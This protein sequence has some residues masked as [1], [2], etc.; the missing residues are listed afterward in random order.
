MKSKGDFSCIRRVYFGGARLYEKQAKVLLAKFPNAKIQYNYGASECALMCMTELNYY[1]ENNFAI[2]DIAKDVRLFLTE[3]DENGVGR[4]CVEGACVLTENGQYCSN[5]LGC[6]DEKGLH[7]VGRKKYSGVGV[8]NYLLDDEILLKNE[9][10]KKGFSFVYR[11]RT[12]FCYEGKIC[13]KKDG[14]T[15]VKSIKLP[16]DAKHKTKLDYHK[17]I[18]IMKKGKSFKNK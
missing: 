10:L 11:D 14:V 15:Y 17:T 3:Q 9:K 6:I 13:D 5:D 12:Y 2:R 8:Y 1:L 16:M 4:I 7:I 18:E